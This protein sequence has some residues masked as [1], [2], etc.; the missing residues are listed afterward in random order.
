M[1]DKFEMRSLREGNDEMI[2]HC[3]VEVPEMSLVI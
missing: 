3:E 1:G 2:T